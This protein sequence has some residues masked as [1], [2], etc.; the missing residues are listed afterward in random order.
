MIN[1][2]WDGNDLC[3]Q[4]RLNIEEVLLIWVSDEVNGETQMS[5]TTWSTNSMQVGFG[6]SW[7]IKIDD[8]INWEDINTSGK[9]ICA[10]QTSC[11]SIFVVMIDSWKQNK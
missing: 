7:E 11:F 6:I 3:I 1:I 5:E 4:L 10:D 8:N 2:L 9:N